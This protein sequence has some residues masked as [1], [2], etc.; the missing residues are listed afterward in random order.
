MKTITG[1]QALELNEALKSITNIGN[2][3][4]MYFVAKNLGL[5]KPVIKTLE[6]TRKSVEKILEDF[7]A[8]RN[9]LIIELGE[10]SPEGKKISPDSAN[11]ETYKS[12]VEELSKKH[13]GSIFRYNELLKSYLED[14]LSDE[15]DVEFRSICLSECPDAGFNG[16]MPI[17]V[18]Y[19]LIVE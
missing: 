10:D 9:N 16:A 18:E 17:L 2:A 6:N 11:W 1:A 15:H 4:F 19:E 7:N 8:E 3:K 14:V 5:L 13:E 12:K